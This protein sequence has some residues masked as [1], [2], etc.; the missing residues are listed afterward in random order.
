MISSAYFP[1]GQPPPLRIVVI[2]PKG[3]GKTMQFRQL[4]MQLGLLHIIYDKLLEDVVLPKA[5]R[6]LGREYEDTLP[7]PDIVLP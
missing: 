2:G 4:A 7:V 3:A 6:R 5:G 1:T